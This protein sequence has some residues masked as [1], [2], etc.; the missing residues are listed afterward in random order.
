MFPTGAANLITDVPGIS[1]GNA[2]DPA[3]LSG[4]TVVLPDGEAVAG[5]DAR[6]GAPGSRETDAL[7]PTCLVDAVHGLVLAGGSVFGL[8]AASGVM[9]WL[10]ERGRGF[11]FRTQPKVCPVVPAANLFDL[12]NGGDKDWGDVPPYRTLG[13]AA[14]DAAG[15]DFALGNAGAGLGALAGRYKGGLGSVSAVWDGITVGALAAVNSF[16]SPVVPG[17]GVFWAAPYEIDGEF[18]GTGEVRF[19][20]SDETRSLEADTKSALLRDAMAA[21]HNTTLG[22][23]ATDALLTPAEAKRVAIMAT[24]GMARA[25]RPVHTPYDG[26]I[27]FTLSTGR[28]ELEGPRPLALTTLGGLA[29][30]AMARAVARGVYEAQSTAGWRG[31]RDIHER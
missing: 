9:H 30:D 23:V 8:D 14:C 16:G 28:R 2:Q 18:G 26:D 5:V 31:Y 7:D 21:G 20:L 29:A 3:L 13:L 27:V 4:V 17:T 1:V 6:G 15:P 24:D 22:V 12:T 19:A 10:A 11:A 25:L